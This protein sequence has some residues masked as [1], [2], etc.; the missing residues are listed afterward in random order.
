[1]P[2]DKNK[3]FC[4]DENCLICNTGG[5]HIS[6]KEIMFWMAFFGLILFFAN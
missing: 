2:S 3:Y 6:L 1:M 4:D 5:Y